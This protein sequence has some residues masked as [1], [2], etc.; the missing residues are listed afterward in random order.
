MQ[1]YVNSG[2]AV[3]GRLGSRIT[4]VYFIFMFNPHG[5][6]YHTSIKIKITE[7]LKRWQEDILINVPQM[8][9]LRIP[10]DKCATGSISP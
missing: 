1:H 3:V 2:N 10:L 5:I 9:R 7:M 8:A 6:E 4:H